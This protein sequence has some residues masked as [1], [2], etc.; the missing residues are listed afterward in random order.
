[1]SM[2]EINLGGRRIGPGH[3]SSL[4]KCPAITTSRWSALAIVDAAAKTGAHALKLQTFT[5]DTMTLDL[6]ERE[7]FVADPDNLWSGSS[8]YQLYQQAHT[9][10]EWHRPI[11]DCRRNLE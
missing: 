3:L 10:W 11:F 7:F 4:P 5:A 2:R 6:S 8:L 1:M 9:P